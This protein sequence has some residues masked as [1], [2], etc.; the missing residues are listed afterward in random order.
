[1]SGPRR[2]PVTSPRTR[3]PRGPGHWPVSRELDEQTALGAVYVR[4]LMRAQLRL[5][6]FTSL[7]MVMAFGGLPLAFVVVPGLAR[8]RMLGVPLP[9]LVLA[10]GVQPLWILT[11]AWHVRRAER[12]ERDFT[13]VV[14][15]S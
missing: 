5:A 3:A 9:W 8:S 6:M 4:W 12:T 14:E 2:V 15:R 10:L 11:A 13:E 1:M 7:V